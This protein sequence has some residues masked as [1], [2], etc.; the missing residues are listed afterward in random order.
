MASTLSKKLFV[1]ENCPNLEWDDKYLPFA[2]SDLSDFNAVAGSNNSVGK[3]VIEESTR[4]DKVRYSKI[5]E[6]IREMIFNV[7]RDDEELSGINRETDLE[8]RLG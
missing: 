4:S 5:K 1:A 2:E 8:F 6:D 3:A 7:R